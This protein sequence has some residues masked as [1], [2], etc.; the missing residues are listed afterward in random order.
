MLLTLVNIDGASR[1]ALATGWTRA[2]SIIR[3]LLLHRLTSTRGHSDILQVLSFIKT[4][5]KPPL[6]SLSPSTQ[7]FLS[8][9]PLMAQ[10]R[11][12]RPRAIVSTLVIENRPMLPHPRPAKTA[13]PAALQTALS[14]PPPVVRG[15]AIIWRSMP[16]LPTPKNAQP[17]LGRNTSAVGNPASKHSFETLLMVGILRTLRSDSKTPSSATSRITS[18]SLHAGEK[19]RSGIV[20]GGSVM[21]LWEVRGR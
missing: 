7:A 3:W 14:C 6:R 12:G 21:R 2:A 20:G 18:G 13:L 15:R 4:R 9:T 17:S 1:W 16:L 5:T 11:E 19:E 10:D 8:W